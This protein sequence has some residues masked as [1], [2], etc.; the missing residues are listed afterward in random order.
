MKGTITIKLKSYFN[1]D[2]VKSLADEGIGLPEDIDIENSETLGLQLIHSLI[3]HLDGKLEI[4]T[5][6][7]TEFKIRF[8]ESKYKK[9][10]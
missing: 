8:N 3:N 9:R 2:G 6:N 4:D 1:G 5:T 10:T 7:G